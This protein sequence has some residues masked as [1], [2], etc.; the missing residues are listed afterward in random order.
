MD[1]GW[2]LDFEEN[3]IRYHA[4]KGFA[5]AERNGQQLWSAIDVFR[6][7]IATRKNVLALGK[8]IESEFGVQ[9]NEDEF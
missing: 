2:K 6:T 1:I 8:A 3:G 4:E 5:Y 7:T 9:E